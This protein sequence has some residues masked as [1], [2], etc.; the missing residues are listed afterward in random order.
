MP[1]EATIVI[2]GATGDLAVKKLFPALERLTA[3]GQLAK[4]STVI[5][6]GR[7]PWSTSEFR[8]FLTE[9]NTCTPA[10]I[11]RIAYAEVSFKDPKGYS[12]LAREIRQSSETLF[13]LAVGP[14]LFS[15]I[16]RGL[17]ENGLFKG[18]IKVL[19]E[20]PFGTSLQTARSLAK[21][22]ERDL[23]AEQIYLV[24]HYLGKPAL[25][26]IMRSHELSADLRYLLSNRTVQSVHVDLL[27]QNGT[28][29]RASYDAIG[30]LRDVGQNHVLAMLAVLFAEYPQGSSTGAWHDARALVIESLALPRRGTSSVR[31]GQYSGYANERG[32]RKR[33]ETETAFLVNASFQK[34]ELSG[35]PVTLR[36][37]KMT[38]TAYAGMTI[39]FR[40]IEPLPSEL[41]IEVQPHARAI[42]RWGD[43]IETIDLAQPVDA[44][45]NVLLDALAGRRRH[46]LGM[47]EVLAAWRY[48]DRLM[49][50]LAAAPLE[51]YGRDTPFFA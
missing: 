24:D 41:T 4:T 21:T 26:A 9:A 49:R 7:R 45:E 43:R 25:Q 20:K 19:F 44:Y 40:T 39:A 35:I 2:M 12:A 1:R 42:F 28:S 3:R 31:R 38:G 15:D 47:Q 32:V 22:I 13:Y 8:A 30:A 50:C 51:P 10:F 34:G 16:T 37:G 23:R 17:A 11:R 29:G 46:F 27:E 18:P 14:D 48:T 33:S 36:S 6:A 5:A